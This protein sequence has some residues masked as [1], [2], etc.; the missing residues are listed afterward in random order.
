M[1]YNL[2]PFKLD[3][4]DKPI[5]SRAKLDTGTLCNY[6]C[7]FCYYKHLLDK[8]K[9]FDL[10]KK[11]IDKLIELGAT[12]LDLSGGESSFH[13]DF[14]KIL[15]YIKSKNIKV[16][17]LT[18]GS[19][20]SSFEF[21]KKAND[22]GLNEILFSL[23]SVGDTHDEITG[24]KGSFKQILKAINNAKKLNILIRI[25]S[26][27]TNKNYHLVDNLYYDLIK[28]IEPFEINFL[29]LN[30][31]SQGSDNE[32]YSY[33]LILKG[34]KNFIDKSNNLNVK[35]INV[36]Y[37]PFCK[38]QGYEKYVCNY[39]QHIYDY[40][41]WSLAM[42]DCNYKNTLENMDKIVKQSRINSYVKNRE[43]VN[44]KY[45]YICDGIEKQSKDSLT[46]VNGEKIKNPIYFRENYY[47]E[48]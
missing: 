12:E 42:Y 38:M 21:L 47:S 37:T 4:P 29:P 14:F 16:S 11:D 25:N 5:N 30:Y 44:C 13:K 31:F 34:V 24:I 41:D 10:I 23:H 26:T 22:L 40:Y 33:D 48:K 6:K 19:M 1:N 39:A 45:F 27:I 2:L 20:F 35:Y 46:P 28:E 15:E 32:I 18:N 3:Y 17:C 9:P 7:Y 43:C 36:R 8:N